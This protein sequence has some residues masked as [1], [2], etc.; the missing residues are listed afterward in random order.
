MIFN[1]LRA[2]TL[3]AAALPAFAEAA[4]FID[5]TPLLDAKN[6]FGAYGTAY[7]PKTRQKYVLDYDFTNSV[8]PEYADWRFYI[9]SEAGPGGPIYTVYKDM[10]IDPTK[11]ETLK[12][13]L[14]S[15]FGINR[16]ARGYYYWGIGSIWARGDF[17]LSVS[18]VGSVPE[19][20]TWAI[21]ILGFGMIGLAMRRKAN[22]VRLL[23]AA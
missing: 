16:E 18:S 11:P 5:T 2:I 23:T 9:D 6:I 17:R 12:G 10:V 14:T 19:P 8:L 15:E 22:P 1:A 13:R 7:Y 21:M 4:P 3:A 20:E